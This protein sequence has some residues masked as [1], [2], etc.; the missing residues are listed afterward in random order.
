M[1]GQFLL[2]SGFPASIA[3]SVSSV[4]VVRALGFWHFLSLGARE[5]NSQQWHELHHEGVSLSEWTQGFR[6]SGAPHQHLSSGQG[7]SHHQRWKGCWWREAQEEQPVPH[8][9]GL[10]RGAA[11]PGGGSGGARDAGWS[12]E[13]DRLVP[14][15]AMHGALLATRLVGL[16]VAFAFLWVYSFSRDRSE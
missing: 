6:E 4:F 2:R 12:A 3:G 14:E 9:G 16:R 1:V 15:Q 7:Q 10:P 5:A 13:P 8:S 11:E